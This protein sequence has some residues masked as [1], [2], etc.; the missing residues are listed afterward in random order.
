MCYRYRRRGFTLV[1][2]V[3]LIVVIGIAAA[4]VL[5]VFQNTVRGSADPQIRKQALAIAEAMLDEILLNAFVHDA[6]A[7]P[8]A[9]FND[10]DDYDGFSTATGM[11]D[12][13]GVAV[14]GLA[15]YNVAVV[16]A[17]ATLNDAPATLPAVAEARRITVTVTVIGHPEMT[18]V[19]DGYRLNY[20]GP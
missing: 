7:P 14:P 6:T 4:G 16:T 10:V 2:L 8:R 17:P 11:T 19:L 15:N 18:V 3:V 13:Q 12:I 1:E 20:A 5:L 9:N